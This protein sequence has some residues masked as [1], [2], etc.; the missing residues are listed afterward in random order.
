[1]VTG[2]ICKVS[3]FGGVKG[4]SQLTVYVEDYMNGKIEI[5]PFMTQTMPIDRINEAFDLMHKGESIRTVILF[6][7]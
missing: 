6:D 3:A 1:M 7:K 2:R 5:D 4:S